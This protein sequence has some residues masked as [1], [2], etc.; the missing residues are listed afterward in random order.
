MHGVMSLTVTD[1]TSRDR[2][3]NQNE[4]LHLTLTNDRSNITLKTTEPL[5]S[6]KHPPKLTGEGSNYFFAKSLHKML[7]L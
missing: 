7:L 2:Y 5:P 3:L 6:N 1:A 4:Y